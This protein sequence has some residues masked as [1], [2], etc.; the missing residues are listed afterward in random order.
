MKQSPRAITRAAR[1]Q[2]SPIL[3]Y[4]LVFDVMGV[5]A[6]QVPDFLQARIIGLEPFQGGL[7]I[8]AKIKPSDVVAKIVDLLTPLSSEDRGRVITASLTLLGEATHRGA[9]SRETTERHREEPADQLG[10][11]TKA[12][13]WQK[14]NS[15]TVDQLGQTFHT[16]DGK[17][18]VIA[19]EMPGKNK[20]EKTLNAYVLTG[21]ARFFD[22]GEPKFSDKDARALCTSAGCYDGPG[23]KHGATLVR[24]LT[25]AQE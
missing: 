6:P 5:E 20:T 23:L 2:H 14:Q 9:A 13:T 3:V 15:L 4:G 8:M 1:G 10:I 24:N 16:A 12:K 21:V 11:S 17:T 7:A 25:A 19:S 18:D 22:N